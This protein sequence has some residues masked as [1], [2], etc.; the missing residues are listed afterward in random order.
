MSQ[1]CPPEMAVLMNST[2]WCAGSAGPLAQAFVRWDTINWERLL[3]LADYHRIPSVV[4]LYLSTTLADKVPAAILAKLKAKHFTSAFLSKAKTARL[5]ELIRFFDEEGIL[6]VPWRGL[7]LAQLYYTEL[8]D[9]NFG[10]LDF[11]IKKEDLPR[12]KKLLLAA[13]FLIGEIGESETNIER[14]LHSMAFY[15]NEND[16]YCELDCHWSF[17]EKKWRIPF[18]DRHVW[19]NLQKVAFMGQPC[20]TLAPEDLLLALIVHHG[21]RS[22]WNKLKFMLDL[23]LMIKKEEALDW[24]HLLTK[25]K[26]LGMDEIMLAG[27]TAMQDLTGQALP[28]ITREQ[29]AGKLRVKW[30]R[31]NIIQRLE[32]GKAH[33]LPWT[34]VLAPFV[35]MWLSAFVKKI[36]R[37]LLPNVNDYEKISFPAPL[38][39]LYYPYR[40]WRLFHKYGIKRMIKLLGRR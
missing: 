16:L 37:L 13:G 12:I 29:A 17:A 15:K 4:Y 21:L 25:A 35:R 33:W 22:R 30:L 27:L 39:F 23:A 14:H 32:T 9:R 18:P 26:L 10:D 36:K 38:H 19:D 2:R 24:Q 11:L 40:L 3:Q 7:T 20:H 1:H 34:I 5:I 31:E 28:P 6:V 8:T